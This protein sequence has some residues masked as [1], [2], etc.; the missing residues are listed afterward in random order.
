MTCKKI[1]KPVLDKI[2]LTIIKMDEFKE[3]LGR[4]SHMCTFIS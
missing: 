2:D 3:T 4:R 1:S